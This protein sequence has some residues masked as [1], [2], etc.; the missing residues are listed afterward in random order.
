TGFR[1]ILSFS[2]M[3]FRICLLIWLT[4]R[5]SRRSGSPHQAWG[6]MIPRSFVHELFPVSAVCWKCWLGHQSGRGPE[7]VFWIC[8]LRRCL[9]YNV[10]TK[11]TYCQ[12]YAPYFKLLCNLIAS[13]IINRCLRTRNHDALVFH[14]T[15]LLS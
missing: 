2:L 11:S 13:V 8:G 12:I 3:L 9:Y 10:F 4:E 14:A 5:K 15:T 6:Y 7:A 1:S